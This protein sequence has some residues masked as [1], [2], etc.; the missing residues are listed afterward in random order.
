MYE[1]SMYESRDASTRYPAEE[2][3]SIFID[4]FGAVNSAIDV[5]CGVGTFLSV[6]EEKGCSRIKG[7]DGAWVDPDL[8][9]INNSCFEVRDLAGKLAPEQNYDLAICLEVAEHVPEG[10]ADELISF[11]CNSGKYVLFSAAIPGQ[12]GENHV[13]EQ[14]QE[15]WREKFRVNGYEV[16]DS[17]REKIWNNPQIPYWYSQ[18]LLVYAHESNFQNYPAKSSSINLVHPRNYEMKL[19]QLRDSNDFRKMLVQRVLSVPSRT[20]FLLRK[21]MRIGSV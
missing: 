18:N 13:N 20:Q 15:Y 5:G 9:Q 11:L 10:N 8:L 16:R 2:I 19:E 14:W 7:I 3:T 4:E 6:L 1:K 12:G 21:Y 17:I